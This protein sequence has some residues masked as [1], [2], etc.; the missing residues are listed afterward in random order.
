LGLVLFGCGCLGPIDSLY[1]PPPGQP[2]KTVY[3]ISNGWHA[4]LV[5]RRTDIPSNLWPE[6]QDFAEYNYL[7]VGWG[8]KGFYMAKTITPCVAIRTMCWPSP[9]VLHVVGFDPPPEVVYPTADLVAVELSNAGFLEL[10]RFA[11]V[12][13]AHDP[14]GE[15][16]RLGPGLYGVSQFYDAHGHYYFPNTCNMWT[17]RALRAAGCPIT[18]PYAFAADNV[19]FQTR[20]FGRVV[21]RP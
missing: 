10:C 16:I 15:P 8:A 6:T 17:A 5:V 21:L 18:P 9:S 7:E 19:V 13:F 3:V 12:S 2:P 20:Q 1:P 11:A 4:G 14:Q